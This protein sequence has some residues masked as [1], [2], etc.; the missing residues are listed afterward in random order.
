MQ[1]QTMQERRKAAR[2][3]DKDMPLRFRVDPFAEVTPI[4]AHWASLLGVK[5]GRKNMLP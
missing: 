2:N 1:D 5:S 4:V 3:R